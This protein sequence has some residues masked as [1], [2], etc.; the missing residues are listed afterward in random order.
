[1]FL[2]HHI[3]NVRQFWSPKLAPV[4]QLETHICRQTFMP[5]REFGERILNETESRSVFDLPPLTH[6]LLKGK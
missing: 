6:L 1:M 4:P 5:C 2:S 3:H